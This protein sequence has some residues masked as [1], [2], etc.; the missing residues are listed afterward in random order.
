M[1][2]VWI[3]VKTASNLTTIH[4]FSSV[5]I[6]EWPFG[7]PSGSLGLSS[8][9]NGGPWRGIPVKNSSLALRPETDSFPSP[10]GLR[11][12]APIS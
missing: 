11:R 9:S 1:S 5:L 8:S 7:A 6:D 12:G 4:A 2:S 10:A 3:A